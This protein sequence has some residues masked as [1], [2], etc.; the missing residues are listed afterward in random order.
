MGNHDMTERDRETLVSAL[1]EECPQPNDALQRAARA[2][3]VYTGIK[4]PTLYRC[5][6]IDSLA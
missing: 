2:H 6:R 1:L 4:E 5:N 3:D